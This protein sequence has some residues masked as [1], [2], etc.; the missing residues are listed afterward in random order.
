[1]NTRRLASFLLPAILILLAVLLSSC[2]TDPRGGGA[3]AANRARSISESTEELDVRIASE[4]EEG[5]PTGDDQRSTGTGEVPQLDSSDSV[6]LSAEPLEPPILPAATKLAAAASAEARSAT[7]ATAE[8]HHDPTKETGSDSDNGS[9][10]V[11]VQGGT[12]IAEPPEVSLQAAPILFSSDP[13]TNA[14]T[15]A[16]AAAIH[17][18][19]ATP[20]TS[21][22]GDAG[23]PLDSSAPENRAADEGSQSLLIDTEAAAD[24]APPGNDSTIESRSEL[25]GIGVAAAGLGDASG[26]NAADITDTPAGLATESDQSVAATRSSGDAEPSPSI[27]TTRSESATAST[28]ESSQSTDRNDIETTTISS[29]DDD[30]RNRISSRPEAPAEQSLNAE[31][32]PSASEPE[33]PVLLSLA[34]SADAPSQST[35]GDAGESEA[36]GDLIEAVRD[37]RS[38]TLDDSL[39]PPSPE[40]SDET[41]SP[42]AVIVLAESVDSSEGERGEIPVP[43]HRL[44]PTDVLE[45]AAMPMS[46]SDLESLAIGLLPP[47][48]LTIVDGG[49]VVAIHT[50]FD[51]DGLTDVAILTAEPIAESPGPD[52]TSVESDRTPTTANNTTRDTTGRGGG[53]AEINGGEEEDLSATH[54]IAATAAESGSQGENRELVIDRVRDPARLF[55]GHAD[56]YTF[57]LHTYLQRGP[58]VELYSEDLLGRFIVFGSLDYVSLSQGRS[59]PG[60][61]S[62]TFQTRRGSV[63]EW[64][65]FS[66]SGVSRLTLR[67]RIGSSSRVEDIDGD[68]IVDIVLSDE[69]FEVGTGYETYLSWLRWN[70]S[71]FELFD[72]ANIVRSLGRYLA[73]SLETLKSGDHAGFLAYVRDAPH[74]NGNGNGNGSGFDAQSEVALRDR[75]FDE[76]FRL[77]PSPSGFANRAIEPDETISWIVHPQILENPFS[78]E[79][80]IGAFF[81]LTL[82]IETSTGGVHLYAARLYISKNPF[83]DRQFYFAPSARR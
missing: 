20:E 39:T 81:P 27:E 33:L 43:G 12:P 46:R 4:P 45:N 78:Q 40:S 53:P 5:D 67:D 65:V 32:A 34:P 76:V 77:V 57:R 15:A 58:G 56:S 11:A 17:N 21:P 30:D 41:D 2:A 72:S 75:V 9:D 26:E 23:P 8:G 62:A 73:E 49:S 31:R 29:G 44:E 22:T 3:V 24:L 35:S 79:D 50:D 64:V 83:E 48:F 38:A 61:I 63:S 52:S 55:S 68:G 66:A 74:G 36:L 25:G 82:R 42:E 6:T 37:V 70:G 51:S 13:G 60:A 14:S 69:N 54:N 28:I 71:G 59:I 19:I 80:A 10:S 18:E 7:D 16:T 47:G 1:M